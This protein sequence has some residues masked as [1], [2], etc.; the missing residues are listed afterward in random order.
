MANPAWTH[1]PRRRLRRWIVAARLLAV[2]ICGAL[3]FAALSHAGAGDRDSVLAAALA[4]LLGSAFG[5]WRCADARRA[6]QDGD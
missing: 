6:S 2:L 5:A 1:R 4:I 3:A